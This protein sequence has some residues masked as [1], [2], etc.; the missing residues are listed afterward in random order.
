MYIHS[1]CV[2]IQQITLLYN[3][4]ISQLYFNLKNTGIRDTTKCFVL[5]NPLIKKKKKNFFL[6]YQWHA[7]FPGPGVELVP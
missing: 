7:E 3:N 1:V 2:C 5:S 6:T 4:I